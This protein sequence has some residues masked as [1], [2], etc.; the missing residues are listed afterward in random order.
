MTQVFDLSDPV[1]PK[2][3]RDFGLP[4][5]QPDATGPVPTMLHGMISAGPAAD[6]IYFGYGTNSGGILQIVDRETLLN[7]PKEPTD[8]NLRR[9]ASSCGLSTS[10]SRST[11]SRSLPGKRMNHTATS[12][13]AAAA[14][15]PTPRTRT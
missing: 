14:S 2:K 3:I 1:H 6:R 8:D 12:A 13:A 11:R 10:R 15:E 4:G 5:Q 9:R 7:G